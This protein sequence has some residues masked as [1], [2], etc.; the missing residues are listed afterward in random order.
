MATNLIPYDWNASVTPAKVAAVCYR[1]NRESEI[2]FLLVR[3]ASGRWTFPKGGVDDDP[4]AAAAA[5]REAFEEAGVRGRIEAIVVHPISA[6]EAQSRSGAPA[7]GKPPSKPI[8]AGCCNWKLRWR[9]IATRLGFRPAGP[10]AVCASPGRRSTAPNW[11]AWSIARSSESR[12]DC[13]N[14]DELAV[15]RMTPSKNSRSFG[16]AKPARPQ[17]DTLSGDYIK[18]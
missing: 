6:P 8:F 4:T 17:D 3:T 16:R 13:T 15:C 9:S 18:S 5:A 7:P 11:S 12:K 10:S 1:V 2:E 14:L